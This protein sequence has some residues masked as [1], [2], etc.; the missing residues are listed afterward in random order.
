MEEERLSSE[1]GNP[2]DDA[3]SL[4][5]G[6]EDYEWREILQHMAGCLDLQ[7]ATLSG[8]FAREVRNQGSW[9][10]DTNHEF[11]AAISD[12]LVRGGRHPW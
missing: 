7:R 5:V 4:P 12:Y 2:G 6:V 1:S 10:L 8:R 11:A 9:D 3:A